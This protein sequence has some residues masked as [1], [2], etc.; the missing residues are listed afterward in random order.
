V[1]ASL[2]LLP[3]SCNELLSQGQN[4]TLRISFNKES[5]ALGT[6]SQELNIPDTDD[7][8]LEIVSS[9]GESIYYGRFGDSPEELSVKAGSYTVSAVSKLFSSPEFDSPVFGDSQI[10]SV[11]SGESVDVT[12]TCSQ[13]NS[14]LRMVVLDSFK[15]T[16]SGGRLSLESEGGSLEYTFDESRTAFFI[17][18]E[19]SISVLN[20]DGETHLTS[21]TLKAK[22][23]L[24]LKLSSSS[25]GKNGKVEILVDTLRNFLSED[26]DYGSGENAGSSIEDAL[27][28]TK[29]RAH[30]PQKDVWVCGYIVGVATGTGKFSFE[31]PFTKDTNIA[32]GLRSGT[33]DKSY[34]ISVELKSGAIRDALNLEDNPELKGRQIYLRGDLVTAYYGIPGLKNISEYQ[35]K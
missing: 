11:G 12:L 23:I 14:G 24:E 22:E 19:V 3:L 33:E 5:S 8:I 20:T 17:P 18:G 1:A 2:L 25:K 28:I 29:A 27:D 35:F 32:L 10:V 4:G 31:A 9:S 7:F 6:K 13:T 34:C 16:F 26:F 15:E 30:A 21:R